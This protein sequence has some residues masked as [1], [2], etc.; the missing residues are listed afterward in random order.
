MFIAYVNTAHKL[1]GI[2][3]CRSTN[4]DVA[5][6]VSSTDNTRLV[7]YTKAIA[8]V[9]VPETLRTDMTTRFTIVPFQIDIGKVFPS[10]MIVSLMMILSSPTTAPAVS[11]VNHNLLALVSI[12]VTSSTPVAARVS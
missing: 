6:V 2:T 7:S 9:I 11:E 1:V 3:T 4:T 8:T 10:V 12:L 5:I